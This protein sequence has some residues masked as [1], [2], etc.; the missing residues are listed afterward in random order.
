M[1]G[2]WW[3]VECG[4][5]RNDEGGRKEKRNDSYSEMGHQ[6]PNF[7]SSRFQTSKAGGYIFARGFARRRG[8][9]YSKISLLHSPRHFCLSLCRRR[10]PPLIAAGTQNPEAAAVAG[11]H[12]S[13]PLAKSKRKARSATES[14]FVVATRRSSLVVVAIHHSSPVNRRSVKLS[15]LRLKPK[16]PTNQLKFQDWVCLV[17]LLLFVVHCFSQLSILCCSLFESDDDMV[18]QLEEYVVEDEAL[19]TQSYILQVCLK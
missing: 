12:S 13:S 19:E 6:I 5:V 17:V 18:F 1:C 4:K 16:Y 8:E 10:P 3:E 9:T 7:R 14:P 11:R 15:Q 2:D